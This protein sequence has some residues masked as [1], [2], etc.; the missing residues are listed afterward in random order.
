LRNVIK[1]K[2]SVKNGETE[3]IAYEMWSVFAN[4]SLFS[5]KF[6]HVLFGVHGGNED[7]EFSKSFLNDLGFMEVFAKYSEDSIR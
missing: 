1:I 6:L 5:K 2:K 4:S 3:S 7:N